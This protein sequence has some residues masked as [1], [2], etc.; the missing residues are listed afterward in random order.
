LSFT[1]EPMKDTVEALWKRAKAAGELVAGIAAIVAV[2]YGLSWL[3]DD[4]FAHVH[5][6]ADH[7]WWAYRVWHAWWWAIVPL[8]MVAGGRL[9]HR[10]I[11]GKG[12]WAVGV[13][14]LGFL[15]FSAGMALWLRL[16][17]YLVDRCGW[18]LGIVLTCA[19]TVLFAPGSAAAGSLFDL[20]RKRWPVID[21]LKREICWVPGW[22]TH[23]K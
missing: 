7:H 15:G 23:G 21:H 20:A 6:H 13:L 2:L 10:R 16:L 12:L 19:V 14:W 8:A 9:W 11:I 4:I 17:M 18:F 22:Q 5:I 3:A 1:S